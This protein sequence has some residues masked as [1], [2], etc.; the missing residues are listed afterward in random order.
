MTSF[1]CFPHTTH[2]SF[3]ALASASLC[4]SFSSSAL[5]S[6]FCLRVA[7]CRISSN[8]LNFTVSHGELW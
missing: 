6:A 4:F 8:E 5:A 7:L 1:Q 3:L 2:T